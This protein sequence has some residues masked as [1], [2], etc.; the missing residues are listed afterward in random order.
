MKLL[1]L[2]TDLHWFPDHFLTF[3]VFLSSFLFKIAKICRMAL[4]VGFSHHFVKKLLFYYHILMQSIQKRVY[5]SPTTNENGWKNNGFFIR[6]L[7]HTRGTGKLFCQPSPIFKLMGNFLPFP[8][9]SYRSVGQTVQKLRLIVIWIPFWPL[10]TL[11][12]VIFVKLNVFLSLK[13]P[14]VK[15]SETSFPPW[16]DLNL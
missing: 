1:T 11:K 4:D 13:L 7:N 12:T 15:L 5:T 2:E 14:S 16:V 10:S 8:K 3:S 9:L 6:G